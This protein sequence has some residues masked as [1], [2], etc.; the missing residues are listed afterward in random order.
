MSLAAKQLLQNGRVQFG[1]FNDSVWDADGRDDQT[2]D[3]FGKPRS[4]LDK[5][6][7]YKQ[8]QYFGGMS[9]RFIFGCALVDLGYC[10]SVFAYLFDTESGE[11]FSRS[12]KR[13]YHL[14]MTLST[15]PV[16]GESRFHAGDLR[17]VQ[18]Y[19]A[20]PRVKTLSLHIGDELHI[21][22]QMP[23]SGFQPMS[24]STRAGYHGWVYANKTAGLPLTGHLTWRGQTFDLASLGAMGHHDFSCGFMRR[25]T[26]WNW[27]CLSGLVTDDLQQKHT[28]GLN[29]STGVNETT[30]SE[31]CAWLAGRC[32]PLASAQFDFDASD[33]LQPWRVST[34][35][36]A[37]NLAFTPL[38]LHKEKLQLPLLKSHFRQIFGRFDGQVTLNCVSYAVTNL[39][40]FVE[41]QFV[42]W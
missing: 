19:E 7:K 2:P 23:E 36:G 42:R 12:V 26:W 27:A 4:S 22:A 20:S 9:Q 29:I 13:P 25:E 15:S 30:Y 33:V 18:A 1:Y 37:I 28:L 24:L 11:L 16:E 40:G 10:N 5:T 14:G 17:V 8:F 32:I 38:G 34:L 21:Q 35:D 31:N 6:L 41:D 3:A 39:S